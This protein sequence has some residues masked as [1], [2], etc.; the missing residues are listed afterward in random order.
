MISLIICTSVSSKAGK[1]SYVRMTSC[2]S[3][4]TYTI[5]WRTAQFE[6]S[7]L[8]IKLCIVYSATEHCP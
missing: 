8:H 1:L 5:L 3:S 4:A 6:Q 2:E 7:L